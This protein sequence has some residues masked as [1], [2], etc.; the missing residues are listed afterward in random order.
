ML[1]TTSNHIQPDYSIP[2]PDRNITTLQGI[3]KTIGLDRNNKKYQFNSKKN[4]DMTLHSTLLTTI[5]TSPPINNNLLQLCIVI[6]FTMINSLTTILYH[7]S[8]KSLFQ[9]STITLLHKFTIN[10]YL[11]LHNPK[12]SN[13]EYSNL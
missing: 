1:S 7:L 4:N 6:P 2:S 13:N 12:E 8:H 9:L 5:D 11:K 3:S 10:T